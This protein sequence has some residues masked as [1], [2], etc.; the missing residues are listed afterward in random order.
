MEN[1]KEC[2][3]C[4]KKFWFAKKEG[5]HCDPDDVRCESHVVN[6]G[7][8]GKYKVLEWRNPNWD[9]PEGDVE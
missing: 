7:G 3:D 4:H 5:D 8:K 9:Y 2:P 6:V 1:M